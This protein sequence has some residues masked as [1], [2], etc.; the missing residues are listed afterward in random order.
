MSVCDYTMLFAQLNT[1]AWCKN[2]F[3]LNQNE[4]LNNS[5]LIGTDAVDVQN[6]CLL[7]AIN[8]FALIALIHINANCDQFLAGGGK[9]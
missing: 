3:T 2:K 5:R 4:P 1:L 6:T 8:A 9:R 7:Y